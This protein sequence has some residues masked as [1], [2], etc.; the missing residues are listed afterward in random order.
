MQKKY[1]SILTN[2]VS[3]EE[4]ANFFKELRNDKRS[5]K[6]FLSLYNIWS[7]SQFKKD[8]TMN[9]DSFDS[10]WSTKVAPPKKNRWKWTVA[11][12]L[13]LIASITS[14]LWGLNHSQHEEFVTMLASKGNVAQLALADGSKIWLNSDS[15]ASIK[16]NSHNVEV[17]LNGE[18]YFD[19]I[20]NENREFTVIANKITIK[21]KGTQFNVKSRDNDQDISVSLVEGKV[22]IHTPSSKVKSLEE[23]LK[24]MKINKETGAISQAFSSESEIIGWKEGKFVFNNQPLSEIIVALEDWYNVKFTYSKTAKV[25]DNY[26][27]IIQRNTDIRDLLRIISI[28]TKTKYKINEKNDGSLNVLLY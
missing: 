20:H 6:E 23:P 27:G 1:T 10:F 16:I 9:V 25:G 26:S 2:K 24:T 14:V 21:D 28:S 17:T 4:R 5:F 11:A 13:A 8:T 3:S 22:D 7:L 19:I 18:G 15:K 12:S